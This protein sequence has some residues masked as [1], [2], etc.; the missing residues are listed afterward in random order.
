MKKNI[1]IISLLGIVLAVTLIYNV[2]LSTMS[3]ISQEPLGVDIEIIEIHADSV[4]SA[5]NLSRVL[6]KAPIVVV[7]GTATGSKSI[8]SSNSGLPRTLYSFK[9][10]EVLKGNVDSDTIEIWQYGGIVKKEV[11][12]K[13]KEYLYMVT[14]NPPLRVGE[15]SVYLLKKTDDPDAYR[16]WGAYTGHFVIREGKVYNIAEL[17]PKLSD[18]AN[19]QV[20][21]QGLSYSEFKAEITK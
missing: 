1:K 3:D 10:D 17:T 14:D 6:A 18:E 19:V 20:F 5:V 7:K 16:L 13:Q 11:E 15:D 4:E 21:K 8:P 9:V 12:G 2:S